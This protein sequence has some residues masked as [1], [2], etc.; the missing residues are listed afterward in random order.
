MAIKFLLNTIKY[1][2]ASFEMNILF[3]PCSI[4]VVNS[5]DY[6][7]NVKSNIKSIIKWIL[8]KFVLFKNILIYSWIQLANILFKIFHL[9][10]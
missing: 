9:C 3:S 8:S 1:F 4:Y 7:F 2:L 6:I 5:I 10:S